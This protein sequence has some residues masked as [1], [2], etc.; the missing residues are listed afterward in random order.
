MA[1]AGKYFESD[2]MK[3]YKEEIENGSDYD[4]YRLYDTMGGRAGVRN[5]SDFIAYRYPAMFY[6]EC[7]STKDPRMNFNYLSDNQYNGL[8]EKSKIKGV[9]AGVLINFRGEETT[10][11]VDIKTIEAMKNAGLKSISWKD[12]E[13]VGIK[14]KGEKIRVRFRYKL[15]ELLVK[16]PEWKG[17][18][19]WN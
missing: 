17:N 6:I 7:K 3:S 10:Y 19:S 14:L 12:C 11:Y 9:F 8:L 13:A 1:N 2:I 15:D 16:I 5:V 4:L 18:M